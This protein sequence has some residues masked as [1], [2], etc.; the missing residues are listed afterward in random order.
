MRRKQY[1][2]ESLDMSY[3]D[4]SDMAYE[5]RREVDSDLGNSRDMIFKRQTEDISDFD[6]PEML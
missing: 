3:D 5:T 4:S 6:S 1:T 2:F